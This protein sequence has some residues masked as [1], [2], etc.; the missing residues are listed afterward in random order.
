MKLREN[1]VPIYTLACEYQLLWKNEGIDFNIHGVS[2]ICR[3]T[4]VTNYNKS[5]KIINFVKSSQT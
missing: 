5:K 2:F 3:L 4:R 1:C